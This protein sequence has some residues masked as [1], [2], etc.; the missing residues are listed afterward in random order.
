MANIIGTT[1]WS[2]PNVVEWSLWL[3]HHQHNHLVFVIAT[4]NGPGPWPIGWIKAV[5]DYKSIIGIVSNGHFCDF[6]GEIGFWFMKIWGLL[7]VKVY[8]FV[9]KHLMGRVRIGWHKTCLLCQLLSNL[10]SLLNY[11]YY[12]S[13]NRIINSIHYKKY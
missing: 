7:C 1:I 9:G 3:Q 5:S 6:H 2:L 12:T 11:T 4:S 8:C 13:I 10:F